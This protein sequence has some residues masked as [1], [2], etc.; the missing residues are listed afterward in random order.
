MKSNES[1]SKF[2]KEPLVFDLTKALR[3]IDDEFMNYEFPKG[4]DRFINDEGDR[5]DPYFLLQ[6]SEVEAIAERLNISE[7]SARALM[8]NE[9]GYHESDLI[10]SNTK[11]RNGQRIKA[12]TSTG[13]SDYEMSSLAEEA[14]AVIQEMIDERGC[15]EYI[16]EIGLGP[17]GFK[18]GVRLPGYTRG[19]V[20]DIADFTFKYD[21]DDFYMDAEDQLDDQLN[22]FIQFFEHVHR[23]YD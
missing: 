6:L 8:I 19:Y 11:V 22:E 17:Y 12:S 14:K 9:L 13:L 21:P 16:E 2:N 10:E 15:G 3:R 4:K 5:I 23:S 18:L 20:A 7:E 1:N